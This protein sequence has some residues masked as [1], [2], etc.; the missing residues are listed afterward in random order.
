MVV[1]KEY[2]HTTFTINKLN[3]DIRI[4]YL[5]IRTRQSTNKKIK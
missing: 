1:M 3:R 5:E 2:I 4:Q